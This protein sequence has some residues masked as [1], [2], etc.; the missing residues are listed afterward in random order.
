MA[1][2][3]ANT[4]LAQWLHSQIEGRKAE[5]GQYGIRTLA[6]EM[7]PVEPEIAR[8]CLNRILYEGSE[9]SPP[10]KAMLAEALGV[11]ESEVPAIRIPFQG[12]AA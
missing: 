9:P 7:N 10:N 6:R 5:R 11:A 12:A 3:L 1:R 2:E 4:D 8:R